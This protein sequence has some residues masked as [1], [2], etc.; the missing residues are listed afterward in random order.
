MS[1]S[2][3]P[4]SQSP[5][6][7]GPPNAYPYQGQ[8]PPMYPGKLVCLFLNNVIHLGLEGVILGFMLRHN[9]G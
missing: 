5:R 7:G 9:K 3:P 4:A 2:T 6:P 1:G 8:R